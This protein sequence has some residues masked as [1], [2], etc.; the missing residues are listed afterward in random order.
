MQVKIL[1]GPFL[2][3]FLYVSVSGQADPNIRS[4]RAYALGGIGVT[5]E[6][7]DAAYSNPA[8]LTSLQHTAFHGGS[9]RSFGLS[10]LTQANA[11]AAI[12]S[13]KANVLFIHLSQFGFSAYQE[14]E[15]GV[16]YAMQLA[17][18]FSA[19]LRFDVH[20][21]SIEGYGSTIIP[22]FLAGIQYQPEKHFTVGVAARNPVQFSTNSEIVLPTVLSA[23]VAYHP[24]E[25][26]GVYFE[27]EKDVDFAP[28]I[29]IAAEYALAESAHIARR[30]SQQSGH[31]SC[32]CWC[33]GE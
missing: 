22:G 7:I 28:R 2:F 6:G 8:G 27:I 18:H 17:E 19:A 10:P 30:W 21:F 23:G 33:A 12:R 25:D 15:A 5:L 4:A 1:I 3:L 14:R 32:R 13:G 20:Q 11:V 26:T 31:L 29:R 24:S 9:A 16:G